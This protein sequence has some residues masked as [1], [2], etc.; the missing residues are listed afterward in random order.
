MLMKH[1]KSLAGMLLAMT[2][3][4]MAMRAAACRPVFYQPT[5]FPV[6]YGRAGENQRL[7]ANARGA[8]YIDLRDG[9]PYPPSPDDFTVTDVTTKQRLEVKVDALASPERRGSY[10]VHPAGGFAVGHE[11]AF[12]TS[13]PPVANSTFAPATHVTIGPPLSPDE[14]VRDT[15]ITTHK[16]SFQGKTLDIV[17]VAL[18]GEAAAYKFGVVSL[19][20]S[21]RKGWPEEI[22]GPCGRGPDLVLTTPSGCHVVTADLSFPQL[23]DAPMKVSGLACMGWFTVPLSPP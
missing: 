13:T 6:G 3:C 20:T 8:L 11:Y 14:L 22:I 15:S 18:T 12:E 19:V 9:V 2:L 1:T 16:N 21:P 4:G 7:P 17:G 23:T 5:G 10:L